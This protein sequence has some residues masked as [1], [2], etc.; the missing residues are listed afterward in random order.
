M[1]CGDDGR[2][3]F[4]SVGGSDSIIGEWWMGRVREI[5]NGRR[6]VSFL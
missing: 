1:S 5:G 2:A 4:I 6:E 3:N